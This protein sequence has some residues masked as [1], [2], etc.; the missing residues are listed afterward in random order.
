MPGVSTAITGSSPG[1]G[2]SD[3]S[4]SWSRVGYPSTGWMSRLRKASANT[5]LEICRFSSM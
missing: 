1:R 2:V 4:I 5:R 3:A